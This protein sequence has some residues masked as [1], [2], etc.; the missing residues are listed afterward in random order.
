MIRP[1]QTFAPLASTRLASRRRAALA[2]AALASIALFGEAARA[3]KP[4]ATEAARPEKPR[5]TEAPDEIVLRDGTR[6]SGHIVQEDPGRFVV[7]QLP[8]G[9]RRVLTWDSVSQANLAT[10]SN[11]I[12][13]DNR[14][15]RPLANRGAWRARRRQSLTY[16]V[17]ANFTAL[18]FPKREYAVTGDCATGTGTAPMSNYGQTS[19]GR[20]IAFGGGLGFRTSYMFL[21]P[22]FPHERSSLWWAFRASAGVDIDVLR[23]RLPGGVPPVQGELCAQAQNRSHDVQYEDHTT[24]LW[25][26][27]LSMGAHLG[28]GSFRTGTT[29][30]GVVLG[31]AYSPSLVIVKP[32]GADSQ[33]SLSYLAA[34]LSVDVTTLSTALPKPPY[35]PHVR[36][37]I[38]LLAPGRD[39][40]PLITTVSIGATWY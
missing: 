35:D 25:R 28:I 16:E 29:W 15:E 13:V 21:P 33:L 22:P 38:G 3:E 26:A 32:F 2:G 6:I 9:R 4:K 10:M 34:E 14:L 24:L 37:V 11:A 23:A 8:D 30:R 7:V 19:D 17:R 18:S 36:V 12:D 39:V 5:A 27:P 31:L 40:A 1:P 20:G